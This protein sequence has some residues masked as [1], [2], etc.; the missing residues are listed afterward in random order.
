MPQKIVAQEYL[1][2]VHVIH[3]FFLYADGF[4][5]SLLPSWRNKQSLGMLL[6]N[7]YNSDH[8]FRNPL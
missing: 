3:N 6:G 5:D 2:F 8:L 7:T 1:V 4:H